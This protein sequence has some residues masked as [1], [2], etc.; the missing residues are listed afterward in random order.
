MAGEI[1]GFS[2]CTPKVSPNESFVKTGGFDDSGY[3][4]YDKKT[5]EILRK[6]DD[7]CHPKT[8]KMGPDGKPEN[9]GWMG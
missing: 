5:G 9:F 8:P 3:T 2:Q 4:I 6:T 1:N 7:N